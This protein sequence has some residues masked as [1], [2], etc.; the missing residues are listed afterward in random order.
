MTAIAIFVKTPGLSPIKTR[1]AA[2]LG[3]ARAEEWHRLAAQAIGERAETA[4]VGPVYFAVAEA[5][6]LDHPLWATLPRLAQG[7]GGLGERMQRVLDQLIERHGS[8]LLLGADTVQFRLQHLRQASTWLADSPARW[9]LG[10]AS[11]GGFWTF[12][13]NRRL[14]ADRWKSVRYSQCDTRQNF[15]A[16]LI[17]AGQGLLLDEL[18]D[19]DEAADLPRVLKELD[20]E[21]RQAGGALGAAID[22]LKALQQPG[23]ASS[24]GGSASLS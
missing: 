18:S 24:A 8:G 11:D 17:D 7:E 1:L 22:C 23:A 16:G 13:S 20:E 3:R 19:L 12:G 9:V 10:P 2:S 15:E 6:A 21:H 14:P 4:A 5:G